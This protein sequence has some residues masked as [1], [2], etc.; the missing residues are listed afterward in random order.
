M[1]FID[2]EIKKSDKTQEAV[3]ELGRV[4]TMV[5]SATPEK[6]TEDLQAKVGWSDSLIPYCK[7]CKKI[8]DSSDNFCRCCGSRLLWQ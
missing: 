6:V 7:N 5:I 2:G 8:V 1:E 3:S 4:A